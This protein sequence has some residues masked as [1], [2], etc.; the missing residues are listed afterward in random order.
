MTDLSNPE[1][2]PEI[3]SKAAVFESFSERLHEAWITDRGLEGLRQLIIEIKEVLQDDNDGFAEARAPILVEVH[4][5]IEL[6]SE[7]IDS[8]FC[9]SKESMVQMWG[10]FLTPPGTCNV[11]LP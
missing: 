1:I 4:K 10:S 5:V 9:G 7:K 11:Y 8:G 6:L 3:A 2:F